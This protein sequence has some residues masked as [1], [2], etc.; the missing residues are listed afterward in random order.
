MRTLKFIIVA[1]LLGMLAIWIREGRGFCAVET[2]PLVQRQKPF[3]G[4]YE[5]QAIIA[6]LIGIWGVSKLSRQKPSSET[7]V[8][9]GPK[10]RSEVLLIPT[11]I[12][13]LAAISQRIAAGRAFSEVI[14]NPP[15]ATE[16]AYLAVLCVIVFAVVLAFKFFRSR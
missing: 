1:W 6:V 3:S 10:F 7:Q 4:E 16:P 12:I 8:P 11:A 9:N 2:L 5:L 14:G 13:A 15:R